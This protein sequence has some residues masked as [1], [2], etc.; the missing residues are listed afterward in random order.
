MGLIPRSHAH[1]GSCRR[2]PAPW[3]SQWA[4]GWGGSGRWARERGQDPGVEL[5]WR[6]QDSEREPSSLPQLALC[7]VAVPLTG[8][9]TAPTGTFPS[10]DIHLSG[11]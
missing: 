3:R 10:V 2:L 5:T 1:L 4:P 8:V 9:P 11:Q 7:T 6:L